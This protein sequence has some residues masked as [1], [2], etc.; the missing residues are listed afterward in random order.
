M[1]FISFNLGFHTKYI[2]NSWC[3]SFYP[4]KVPLRMLSI[5]FKVRSTH[6]VLL[7]FR[8]PWKWWW[9]RRQLHLYLDHFEMVIHFILWVFL[10]LKLSMM[11]LFMSFRRGKSGSWEI[12]ATTSHHFSWFQG[13]AK[14]LHPQQVSQLVLGLVVDSIIQA[15]RRPGVWGCFEEC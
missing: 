9:N 13:G 3:M 2:L 5:L 11:S 4:A 12:A 6:C 1:D 10:S 14:V 8:Q 7:Q 15:F